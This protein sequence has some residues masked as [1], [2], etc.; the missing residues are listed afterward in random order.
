AYYRTLAQARVNVV[1]SIYTI[2]LLGYSGLFDNPR[3]EPFIELGNKIKSYV[4]SL[5]SINKSD[6]KEKIESMEKLLDEKIKETIESFIKRGLN[7]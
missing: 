7:K 4:E 1:R 6:F 3:L 5:K 2:F